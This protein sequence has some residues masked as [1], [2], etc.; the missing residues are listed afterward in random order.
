VIAMLD[1]TDHD[2]LF[3][4]LDRLVAATRAPL[5]DRRLMLSL[6]ADLRALRAALCTGRDGV[7][8]RLNLAGTRSNAASA[9]SRIA[10]L[11]RDAASAPTNK[12]I[13]E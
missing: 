9:Y 11:G 1:E 5:R 7:A 4:R 3:R 8:H 6:Q 13:T 10:F 12:S 2:A